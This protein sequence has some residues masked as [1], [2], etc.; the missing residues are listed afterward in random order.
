MGRVQ[1]SIQP[2]L[3]GTAYAVKYLDGW[4]LSRNDKSLVV[5]NGDTITNIDLP[6]MIKHHEER[7]RDITVF[8]HDDATHNGGTFILNRNVLKDI[9]HKL[10]HLTDD[11]IPKLER[12]GRVTL[13]KS[14]AYYF[15]LGTIKNLKKARRFFNA[16][17]ADR[18]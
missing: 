12:E 14:D 3:Y 8:T 4:F 10:Y 18:T 1:Y 15:D 11:L 13:Y 2:E 9:P 6:D 17:T 7:G 5:M 16:N